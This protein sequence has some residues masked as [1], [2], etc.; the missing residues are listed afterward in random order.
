M[1]MDQPSVIDVHQLAKHFRVAEPGRGVAE[2]LTRLVA[3]RYRTIKA[4]NDVSFC[5]QRGEILGYL[6]PNGAGKSTTIKVLTGVLF[7]TAGAVIVNGLVPYRQRTANAYHIG[8]V[9]GQRSQLWWDLPLIDSFEILRAMYKVPLPRYRQT[10]DLLV[11]LLQM[12]DFLQQPV[13]KLSLGQKMRGDIAAA[14]LHDPPVLYLDEPTIGLD[15]ISKNRVLQ[16]LQELNAEKH[17]TILLTTHNLSDVEQVC[18]RI[19]II[20]AGRVVLDEPRDEILRR[21]GKQRVLVVEFAGGVQDL[22][23]P[24]GRVVKEEENKLWIEFNRDETSAFDLIASLDRDKGIVDVS[25]KEED[26][27]SIVARIY[28]SGVVGANGGSRAHP[29]K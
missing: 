23:L 21:F 16:F 1:T 10:L 5:V 12:K 6:G 29:A 4:V 25:I 7:P 19:L 22:H 9:Y 14:L 17:T 3:P 2:K 26:I 15:V 18:P 13:R 11:E 8:V 24:Q 27:E 20:D 28:E